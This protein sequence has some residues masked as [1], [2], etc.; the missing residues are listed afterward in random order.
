MIEINYVFITNQVLKVTIIG[1]VV[2]IGCSRVVTI[3]CVLGCINIV[4]VDDVVFLSQDFA[5]RGFPYIVV[6]LSGLLLPR[7]LM[8]A[9]FF[10]DEVHHMGHVLK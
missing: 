4:R 9:L 6:A 7:V 10:I 5:Y 3:E 2:P 8:Q 1:L